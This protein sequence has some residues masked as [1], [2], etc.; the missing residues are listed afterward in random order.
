ML[1][2]TARTLTK[3]L[4]H[5]HLLHLLPLSFLAQQKPPVPQKPTPKADIIS[6]LSTQL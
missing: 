2:H 3:S 5:L 4:S 6:K 1:V